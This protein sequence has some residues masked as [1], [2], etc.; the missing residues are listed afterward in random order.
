MVEVRTINLFIL[1][2]MDYG[3]KRGFTKINLTNLSIFWDKNRSKMVEK[4]KN[5][6][7]NL[8]IFKKLKRVRKT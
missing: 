5:E 4:K 7:C 3:K 6:S 8:L 1:K 2:K